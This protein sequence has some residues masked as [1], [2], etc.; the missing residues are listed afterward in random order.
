MEFLYD[1][2]A[3]LAR[4]ITLT[5]ALLVVI[6]SI[7]GIAMRGR[8][9]EQLEIKRLNDRYRDMG[10]MLQQQFETSRGWRARLGAMR[11][12]NKASVPTPDPERA[13]VFVMRFHGDIRASAVDH[14]REEVSAVLTQ[15]RPNLDKALICIESGGGMIPHYGLAAAQLLRLRDA[16]LDM[17]VCVD[18]IAASGGY[19]MA[20]TGHRIIAAPFAIVGSIGVVAQLPNFH[21]W[22]KRREVDVEVLTSGRHKRTLTLLG[23]NTAEGR[24][25]FQQELEEAHSLFKA[26]LAR[27]RPALDMNKV[28]TGEHWYGEQALPLG[29]IDELGTSDQILMKLAGEFDLY[30]ISYKRHQPLGKRLSGTITGIAERL[31]GLLR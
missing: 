3:F 2:L 14:L 17:T 27:Y 25:K 15:A 29:L 28:G 5:V 23:Q 8:D 30:Q 1:Y 16:G 22:L 13:R 21:R 9:Q 18:R 19:L 11:G 24:T 7:A 26:F 12:R 10:R 6:G 31:V 20:A 4:I